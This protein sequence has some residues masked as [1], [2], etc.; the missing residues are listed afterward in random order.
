[1]KPIILSVHAKQV[2]AERN[3]ELGWLEAA[4]SEP[5]RSMPDPDDA[6]A[7]RRF[8]AIPERGGRILRVVCRE[9]RDTIY[10]V[11]VFFDRRARR[12]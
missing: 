6:S 5:E 3:I 2:L 11:T 1:M 12:P 8:R 10:I 4:L 9:G 7:E